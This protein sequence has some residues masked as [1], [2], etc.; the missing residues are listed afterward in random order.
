MPKPMMRFFEEKL[1]TRL[2]LK[3]KR[4]GLAGSPAKGEDS[5]KINVSLIHLGS[6]SMAR[7]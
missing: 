6:L 3:N 1:R 4:G 5:S 7:I 2:L